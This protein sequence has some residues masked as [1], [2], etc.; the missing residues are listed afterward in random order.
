MKSES[1]QHTVIKSDNN[2]AKN[3]EKI[4]TMHNEKKCQKKKIYVAIKK[5]VN[6]IGSKNKKIICIF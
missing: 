4:V 2:K 1:I 3:L 6:T 5:L